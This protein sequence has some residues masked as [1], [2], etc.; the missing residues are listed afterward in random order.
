MTPPFIIFWRDPTR[1][2]CESRN[3]QSNLCDRD[4]RKILA[5]PTFARPRIAITMSESDSRSVF[6][7]CKQHV[8]I[9]APACE[10]VFHT[11]TRCAIGTRSHELVL[12]NGT[13]TCRMEAE[14][15]LSA[16]IRRLG[17]SDGA[18]CLVACNG[19]SPIF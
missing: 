5:K 11:K 13:D 12:I 4:P 6:T 16:C 14:D 15:R 19:R 1:H 8:Q 9:P 10:E 18:W 7:S 3:V 17:S 2:G